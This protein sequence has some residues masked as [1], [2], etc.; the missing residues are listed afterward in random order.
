MYLAHI[1]CGLSLTAVGR[2]FDRD[3]STV[4]HA[5]KRIEDRRANQD[6]D[7][8]VAM[9]EGSARTVMRISEALRRDIELAEQG[10][11]SWE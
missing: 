1:A 10:G 3:R 6:F 11:V 9:M 5:Y 2:G 7:A 8:A 4:A